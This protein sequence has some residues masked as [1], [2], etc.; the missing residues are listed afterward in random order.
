MQDL[1]NLTGKFNSNVVQ[2]MKLISDSSCANVPLNLEKL[3]EAV[4]QLISTNRS[5]L[6]STPHQTAP[7]NAGV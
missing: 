3:G 6:F 5:S 4:I 7:L 1:V 2:M